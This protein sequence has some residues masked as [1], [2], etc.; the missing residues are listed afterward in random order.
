MAF[1]EREAVVKGC[2]GAE[3]M[4]KEAASTEK[5]D[6]ERAQIQQRV[7]RLREEFASCADWVLQSDSNGI[8]VMYKSGGKA[9][10]GESRHCPPRPTW[11]DND[12]S[13]PPSAH[14]ARAWG[15]LTWF[16]DTI[17]ASSASAANG[18][19]AALPGVAIPVDDC[20]I[21]DTSSRIFATHSKGGVVSGGSN[22][23][24]RAEEDCRGEND[25]AGSLG[26][27]WLSGK[28]LSALIGVRAKR[29]DDGNS[30]PNDAGQTN[31]HAVRG[32]GECV[33][34]NLLHNGA[35]SAVE[36]DGIVA[37]CL[38]VAQ[39]GS[40]E[41]KPNSAVSTAR[42]ELLTNS[43]QS[44]VV[45][46]MQAA[47]EDAASSP[48]AP[49]DGVT[50]PDQLDARSGVHDDDNISLLSQGFEEEGIWKSGE[51]MESEETTEN[52]SLP[53][54]GSGEG[55]KKCFGEMRLE[56][57][58]EE[59]GDS[60]EGH[61]EFV[62]EEDERNIA[63]FEDVKE[64]KKNEL[65]SMRVEG[66][67][68]TPMFYLLALLKEID[69]FTEWMPQWWGLGVI[70]SEV[71]KSPSATKFLARVAL[72]LPP[73]FFNRDFIFEIDGV[74]CLSENNDPKQIVCLLNSVTEFQGEPVPEVREGYVRAN[75]INST[76]CLTPKANASTFVQILMRVNVHL[77]L[78]PQWLIDT[79]LKNVGH[80]LLVVM[81]G[82]TEIVRQEKYIA[83][84]SDPEDP[85]YALIRERIDKEL[86]DEAKLLPLVRHHPTGMGSQ[87]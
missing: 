27:S 22:S 70:E 38:D 21:G 25:D 34:N 82:A 65:F 56:K 9:T 31:Y 68:E 46:P 59:C 1:P 33:R 54:H 71:L 15:P 55:I 2:A 7:D 83:R 79:A 32:V 64:D 10:T 66:M 29:E 74:D 73:P 50:D 41:C 80:Q 60:G 20:T 75:L 35:T 47:Q 67:V 61:E 13:A 19:D 76:V 84:M 16:A 85:F 30:T 53:A 86:P 45:H 49:P 72:G 52:A 37:K 62:E 23:L 44:Q 5:L 6:E 4:V 12:E 11:L 24:V 77:G 78:I 36:V 26:W 3:E 42:E 51:S 40:A 57:A 39:S 43:R 87:A 69:L 17:P 63:A 48:P 14:Q 8:R 58:W 28:S 18:G 81:R